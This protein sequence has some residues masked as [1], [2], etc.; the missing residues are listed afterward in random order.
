MWHFVSCKSI[1]LTAI[2]HTAAMLTMLNTFIFLL[3]HLS[4]CFFRC[5][6]HNDTAHSDRFAIQQHWSRQTNANCPLWRR[7]RLCVPHLPNRLLLP[8]LT[9]NTISIGHTFNINWLLM[10]KNSTRLIVGTFPAGTG[11][12]HWLIAGVN[13]KKAAG[14][15]SIVVSRWQNAYF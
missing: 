7:E 5:N 9:F 4:I 3:F 11:Q 14:N 13:S 1:A 2:W 8:T 6:Y 15:W 12:S 10:T